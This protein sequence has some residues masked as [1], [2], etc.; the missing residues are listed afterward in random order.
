MNTMKTRLQ[1]L[2]LLDRALAATTD[3]EIDA[4][5]A[6][7]DD[8]HREA[9]ERLADGVTPTA[10]RDA[11]SKGRVNG[12]FESI[13]VVLADACLADCI[14]QLG[15]HSDNPTSD[16]LREVL[17]GLVERHGLAC[18]RLMLATTVVGEAPASAI[19]RDLLKHD[20]DVKLPPME[21][22]PIA[23]IVPASNLSAAEREAVKAKRR[24]MKLRRQAEARARREQSARDRHH[25]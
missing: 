6:A 5:V 11:A 19:V 22:L 8:D 4:L 3:D 20:D 23:P 25:H 24:E 21:P 15:E 18:T 16:Q 7:L 1:A 13:A 10:I 2:V 14:E 17:P 12:T 9:I